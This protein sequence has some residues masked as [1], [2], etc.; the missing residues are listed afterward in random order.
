MD[1]CNIHIN[2]VEEIY[3]HDSAIAMIYSPS[4]PSGIGGMRKERIRARRS[5]RHGKGRYDTVFVRTENDPVAIGR[6]CL[7][8]QFS[9]N[10]TKYP[11][12][13]I[14]WFMKPE[15]QPS[16]LNG[17][18]VVEPMRNPDSSPVASIVSVDALIRAAHLLPAFATDKFVD[19]DIRFDETLDY[20]DTFYVNRYV[21]HHSFLIL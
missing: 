3:L 9:Y 16:E 17:M 2:E 21:D 20:F 8:F 6:V 12:A 15:S 1:D 13:L 4:D 5:W 14:H 10:G 18:W 19:K 11:S 7:F